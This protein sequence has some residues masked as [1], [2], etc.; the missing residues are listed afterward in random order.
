M[1]NRTRDVIAKI[2]HNNLGENFFYLNQSL[3]K[4]KNL[5]LLGQLR[6]KILIYTKTSYPSYV[7]NENE[8]NERKKIH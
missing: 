5:P 2:L 8:K 7:L 6:K 4:K 1:S 3:F